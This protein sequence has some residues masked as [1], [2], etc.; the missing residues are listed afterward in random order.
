MKKDYSKTKW[1]DNK[2]RV[3]AANL[4]KIE[5]ALE[6]LHQDALGKDQIEEGD[7]IAISS[8]K[9][10]KTISVTDD[11]Q[12]S[13]TCAGIEYVYRVPNDPDLTTLYFVL[14]ETTHRLKEIRIGRTVIFSNIENA[15]SN[16]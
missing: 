11:V 14:D 3:N 2:T 8:K 4:G 13:E 7:G 15:D 10:V 12:R 6:Y 9:G 16:N 5:D 1:V